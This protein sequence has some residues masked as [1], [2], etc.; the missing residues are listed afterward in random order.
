MDKVI[1][2]L[3]NHWFAGLAAVGGWIIGFTSDMYKEQ[4]RNKRERKEE[5]AKLIQKNSVPNL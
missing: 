1:G 5:Y 4:W 2:F 3:T